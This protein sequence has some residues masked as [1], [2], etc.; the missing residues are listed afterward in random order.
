MSTAA[1]S[2][3]LAPTALRLCLP[4]S[5]TPISG[6][7][8][9]PL[10]PEGEGPQLPLNFRLQARL[11]SVRA[12]T[13]VFPTYFRLPARC[14]PANRPHR[15]AGRRAPPWVPP[16]R[17]RH[18][19]PCR[20]KVA[21][22]SRSATLMVAPTPRSATLMVARWLRRQA[23]EGSVLLVHALFHCCVLRNRL[24]RVRNQTLGRSAR[25]C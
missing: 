12:C 23:Q 10:T 4:P 16:L 6:S 7:A 1:V 9:L 13:R 20:P 25:I 18:S 17:V 22:T 5:L 3:R 8:E 24:R 21:L 14:C 2:H 15:R 19:L 11:T